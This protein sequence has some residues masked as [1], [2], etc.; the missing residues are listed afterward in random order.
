MKT[1]L[2]FRLISTSILLFLVSGGFAQSIVSGGVS[3]NVYV[4]AYNIRGRPFNNPEATNIEGSPL[5]NQNWGL[6]TVY[7]KDGSVAQNV[8]LRFN[9]EKNELYFNREGE[10]YVFNDPVISFRMNYSVS[11]AKK[12]VHFR[13]GYPVNGRLSKETFYEVVED[14]AKFQLINYRFIYLA[15]SYQ[16]GGT[17][18]KIFTEKEELYVFDV[19]FGKT[20]KI[21]RSEADVLNALPDL[22]EKIV[23]I[24][25]KNKLKL[26]LNEDMKKLFTELNK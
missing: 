15:D 9:L 1:S 20:S 19:A 8:E 25:S 3:T 13:S 23:S 21:K 24:V 18:K 16:Y 6:G 17:A 4:E 26:K 7:F 2:C 10:M 11:T 14:G 22:K 5:L 12:E